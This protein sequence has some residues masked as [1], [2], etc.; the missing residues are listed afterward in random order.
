MIPAGE[1]AG[2]RVSFS[3]TTWHMSK[4]RVQVLRKSSPREV[5]PE[6]F[7]A[8]QGEN[9]R[10][11]ISSAHFTLD[12]NGYPVVSPNDQGV[13]TFTLLFRLTFFKEKSER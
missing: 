5:H 12:V 2:G 3:D 13:M 11:P 4:I 6:D 7:P 9:V 1:M 8:R 10:R